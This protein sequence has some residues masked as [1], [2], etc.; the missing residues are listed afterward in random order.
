MLEDIDW[1][2]QQATTTIQG[3]I[4]ILACCEEILLEKKRSLSCLTSVLDFFK[5]SSGTCVSPPVSLYS[6]NEGE[7]DQ[8]IVHEKIFLKLSFVCQISYFL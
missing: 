3:I 5:S 8:P 7:D 4:T 2:R 6:G 1:N